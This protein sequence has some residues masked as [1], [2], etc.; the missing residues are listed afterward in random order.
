MDLM[1]TL[2]IYMSA[3]MALAVQNTAAPKVTPTPS[4]APSAVVETVATPG[5]GEDSITAVPPELAAQAKSTAKLT[6]VPVPTITPKMKRYHNLA[7][8]AKGK[9]VRA[10]QE[11]LIEM[12]YLPEGSADGAYGRKTFNAVKKFQ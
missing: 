6:T 4:P 8:G 5:P 10:L 3:T 11:K 9:E 2:L 7:M 1:R 12:G